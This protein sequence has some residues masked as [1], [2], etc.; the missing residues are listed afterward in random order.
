MEGSSRSVFSGDLVRIFELQH[1]I[2]TFQQGTLTVSEY[3]TALK[4]LWEELEQFRP[5]PRC[6]CVVP[7]RCPASRNMKLYQDQDCT[8]RFL[9]GLNE[10]FSA[11]RSQILAIEPFPTLNK[12]FSLVNQHERQYGMSDSESSQVLANSAK[13]LRGKNYNT[14]SSDKV[15]THCGRSGHT[16]EVCY[17]KH[18][19]P[20]GF[21]S[22]QSSAHNV[23]VDMDDDDVYES[24]HSQPTGSPSFNGFTNEQVQSLMVMSQQA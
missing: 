10:S 1:E 3:F 19:F 18:G 13:P 16:I 21:K 23:T 12:V 5:M 15:C 2:S 17:R 14:K 6:V 7:C 4:K 9:M 8:M 22:K 20:Q 11:I 24:S